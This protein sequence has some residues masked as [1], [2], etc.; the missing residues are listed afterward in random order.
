VY[1]YIVTMG[2]F[3][4]GV[5]RGCNGYFGRLPLSRGA[6]VTV[7]WARIQFRFGNSCIQ[8]LYGCLPLSRGV[9]GYCHFGRLYHSVD[10]VYSFFMGVCHCQEAC[11]VTVIL[12]IY[13]IALICVQLR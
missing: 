1:V 7:I 3:H 2:I 10:F 9:L 8:L 11:W 12:G 6:L 4:S 5:E 13:T